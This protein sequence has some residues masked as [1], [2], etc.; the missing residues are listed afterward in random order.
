MPAGDRTKTKSPG[1]FYRGS[2]RDRRYEITYRCHGTCDNPKHRE[3]RNGQHWEKVHGDYGAAREL[4]DQRKRQVRELRGAR[5]RGEDARR[6]K[7]FRQVTDEYKASPDFL[8]LRRNTKDRY[9]TDLKNYALP[10]FGDRPVDEITSKDIEGWLGKLRDR[11]RQR[12]GPREKGLMAYSIKGALTALRVVMRFAVDKRYRDHNPARALDKRKMPKPDHRE[13]RV[14]DADE[15]ARLFEHARE[16]SRLAFR[17]MAAAGARD[18]EAL[19]VRWLDLDLAEGEVEIGGQMENG[20]R[21]EYLKTARSRRTRPLPGSLVDELRAL[22]V[23]REGY[24]VGADHHLVLLDLTIDNVIRDFAS[25]CEAAG[26]DSYGKLLT[27]YS[28]RHGYGSKLIQEGFKLPYVSRA[29][30]HASETM[31]A[32]V[33]VHEFEAQRSEEDDRAAAMLEDFIG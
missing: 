12:K 8:D 31:T 23:F 30:G 22:R 28:L 3:K 9:S 32:R 21:V 17:L 15:L 16:R 13:R 4:L 20:R 18:S 25:A 19:G 14:L 5:Q 10:E 2:D 26:I 29:L 7:T 27:P 33:Y 6:S 24:E 1:V 11:E